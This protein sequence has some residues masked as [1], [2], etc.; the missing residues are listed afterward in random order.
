MLDKFELEFDEVGLD[1][2]EMGGET[3]SYFVASY[4]ERFPKK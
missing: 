4:L 2:K 3:L 1:E